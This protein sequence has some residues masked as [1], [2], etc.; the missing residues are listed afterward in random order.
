MINKPDLKRILFIDDEPTWLDSAKRV[1]SEAGYAIETTWGVPGGWE[2]LQNESFDLVLADLKKVGLEEATFR[3]VAQLQTQ[4]GQRVAVM[5]PTELT[6]EKTSAI[7]ELGAHDCIDKPYDTSKLLGLVQE[8]L[9]KKVA[10]PASAQE[11]PEK[12]SASVL[13]IED[14]RDWR[15]RLERY[16][17]QEPC[18]YQIS[19]ADGYDVAAK[20][21]RE[22]DFDL[23]VLD[24]RLMD[25]S[26]NFEGMEL[27]DLLKDKTASVVIVS[28]YGKVEHVKD[29]FEIHGISGYIPK[30]YFDPDE[31]RQTVR[32]AIRQQCE[33]R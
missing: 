19:I 23:V 9:V 18:Q 15:E 16:L 21:L 32:K 29:G 30:Q 3:D 1:L 11:S 33:D 27:L 24:L 14:D 5:F 26:E 10:S 4:R 2:R 8:Q 13:I 22:C 7:F 6:T 20:L 25:S 28:A 17:R 12:Q 31:Y